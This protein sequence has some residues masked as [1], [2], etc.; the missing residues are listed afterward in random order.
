V[1]IMRGERA[2]APTRLIAEGLS[3][4]LPASRLVTVAG[5]GHMGPLTHVADVTALIVRHVA[6]AEAGAP[7]RRRW[8]VI[9]SFSAASQPAEAVS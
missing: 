1:L 8:K 3:T 4:L 7:R 2:P 9:D 5:A 6:K